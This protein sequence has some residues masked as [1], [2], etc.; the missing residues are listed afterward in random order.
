[1]KKVF[2]FNIIPIFITSIL[3][4]GPVAAQILESS[5]LPI[6]I[7]ETAGQNIP[8][9]PKIT[10]DM[11]IIYNGPGMINYID[12]PFNEYDGKI[13]IELRGATS[14]F[15]YPKKQY[16]VETRDEVGENN[17]VPL[18]GMPAENDWVLYAP[19]GDKT[20]IR[21]VLAYK[22]A[23]KIMDYAPRT[24]FCELVLNGEY[25]GL[26]VLTE[27]IKRDKNRVDV[28]RMEVTDTEGDELTGGYILKLD[29]YAG[30]DTEGFLS[31]YAP[32][33]GAAAETFFQ[34]HYPKPADIT[35]AQEAYI[36]NFIGDLDDLMDSRDFA[37][38]LSGYEN[39]IDPATF[40]DYLLINEMCKNVDAYR[41]SAF[42]YKDKN[43]IDDR[44]KAGPVWDFNLA[45]GNVDF[46]MGP[47]PY[48]WVL[49]YYNFCPQDAWLIHFWWQRLRK[50]LRFREQDRPTE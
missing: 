20:L 10:A 27:K 5:H 22:L 15:L 17:N 46:C 33:P 6:V 19:Y 4:F 50:E 3:A 40:V 30:E 44:L 23:E 35:S 8:D 13:G 14:Q 36:Q 47:S 9:E 45:F 49:D 32:V 42:L 31:D 48:D 25:M 37:D 34:Y 43:S 12:D 7:I 11:G 21:N 18:L 24:R 28:D 38:S 1:M 41:L 39:F 2:L 29:K 26:Y 16:A